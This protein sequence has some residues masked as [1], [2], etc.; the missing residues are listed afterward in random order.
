MFISSSDEA[1]MIIHSVSK[2]DAG[3]YKC[4]IS[5]AGESQEKFLFVIGLILE[6]LVSPVT[7]GD[8][9][10]LHCKNKKDPTK[11][12][13]DF[14]RHGVRIHTGYDAK[15]T[16]P[17]VSKDDEGPYKCSISGFGES[18]ETQLVIRENN[19][20]TPQENQKN[21]STYG[22]FYFFVRLSAV[23]GLSVAGLLVVVGVGCLNTKRAG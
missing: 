12:I 16:I 3:S 20:F 15:M 6:G 2:S 5:G 19:T 4:K 14:Y 22:S 1:A 21:S 7:E 23:I 8:S 10:T 13:A 9:V 11:N 18:A 17:R